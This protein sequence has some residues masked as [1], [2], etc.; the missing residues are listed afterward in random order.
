MRTRSMR[1]TRSAG[2]LAVACVLA[3]GASAC[4]GGAADSGTIDKGSNS[5]ADKAKSVY[6]QIQSLPADQQR[7]KAEEL[8]KKEGT[9]SL[10]T[11]LTE[12]VANAVVKAFK[13][14][15]GIEVKL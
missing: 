12:D 2:L 13:T 9:L 6:E 11:S 7:A 5:G 15:F 14:Q 4:G 10:Y 8:A 3:L 1:S